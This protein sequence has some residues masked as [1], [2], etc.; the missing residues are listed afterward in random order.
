MKRNFLQPALRLTIFAAIVIGILMSIAEITAEKR[1]RE[2][3]IRFTRILNSV[4]PYAVPEA[5]AW[6]ATAYQPDTNARLQAIYPI[7][8]SGV[9]HGV[10]IEV[11]APD[12]YNDDIRLLAG[13]D[14]QGKISNVRVIE[15][16][17]TPGLGDRIE[18]RKSDWLRGLIG[19]SIESEPNAW[20]L[21]GQFENGDFNHLTGATVTAKAV[22]NVMRDTMSELQPYL[23]VLQ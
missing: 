10:V 7:N 15:H 1:D 19:L 5:H 8:L 23:D 16:H 11:I 13:I 17:E 3:Q 20:R 14:A 2:A 12:G 9:Y 21:R 4:A 6:Q 22:L 18:R